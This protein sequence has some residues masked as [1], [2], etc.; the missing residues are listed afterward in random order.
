MLGFLGFVS[1]LFL[2]FEK[3]M[4]KKMALGF[5]GFARILFVIFEKRG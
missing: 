3:G 5:L 1:L 4:R 2:I